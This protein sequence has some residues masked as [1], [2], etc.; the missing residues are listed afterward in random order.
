MLKLHNYM[1]TSKITGMLT[2]NKF[3]RCEYILVDKISHKGVVSTVL[4]NKC[5]VQY[6]YITSYG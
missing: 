6:K 3:E 2:E 4:F 1:I 5:E